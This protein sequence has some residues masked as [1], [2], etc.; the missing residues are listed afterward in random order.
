MFEKFTKKIVD[1][2]L[3]SDDE[4]EHQFLDRQTVG[5]HMFAD[6]SLLMLSCG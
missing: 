4:A 2:L 3:G 1:S 6:R 5:C